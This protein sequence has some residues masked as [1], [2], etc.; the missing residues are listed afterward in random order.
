MRKAALDGSSR[1]R[2]D[3]KTKRWTPC[4]AT[5][6]VLVHG[7]LHANCGV[8]AEGQPLHF[9]SASTPGKEPGQLRP[10]ASALIMLWKV[11]SSSVLLP[12]HLHNYFPINLIIH[13]A[14]PMNLVAAP[15]LLRENVICLVHMREGPSQTTPRAKKS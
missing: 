13:H 3:G 7:E 14:S 11:R 1:C 2:G 9:H 4:P 12:V 15:H 5:G 10:F 6:R 8:P